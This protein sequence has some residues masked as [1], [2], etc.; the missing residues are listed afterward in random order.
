MFRVVGALHKA[1]EKKWPD[2][3]LCEKSVPRKKRVC[4]PSKQNGS[5]KDTAKRQLVR[6]FLEASPNATIQEITAVTGAGKFIIAD[7]RKEMGYQLL[8][9]AVKSSENRKK[10]EE[11]FSANPGADP[12][13]IAKIA[14]VPMRYAQDTVKRLLWEK[15]QEAK[16]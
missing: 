1:A 13:E 2:P 10:V 5:P 11:A 4:E 15:A 16:G 7:V 9:T 8:P 12:K 6:D 14:G 3:A